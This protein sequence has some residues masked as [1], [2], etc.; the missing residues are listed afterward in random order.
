MRW[1]ILAILGSAHLARAG[2]VTGRLLLYG[3]PIADYGVAIDGRVPVPV[4]DAEGRFALD[5]AAGRHRIVFA[6]DG[7]VR[8]VVERVDVTSA[9]ID[10]GDVRAARGHRITGTVYDA[11]QLPVAG[12]TVLVFEGKRPS[13]ALPDLEL[14]ALG[15]H[16]AISGEDGT[17]TLDGV[18]DVQL[19][20][21]IVAVHGNRA[22]TVR[23]LPP[24]RDEIDHVLAP[25]GAIVGS[26]ENMDP[27]PLMAIATSVDH[28]DV[29]YEDMVDRY[30]GFLFDQLPPG[31]YDVSLWLTNAVPV[32]V[33]V[34]A[35]ARAPV[36]FVAPRRTVDLVVAASGCSYVTL[37]GTR[38]GERAA[39]A[40][41]GDAVCAGPTMTFDKLA[42][43]TYRVCTDDE[44]DCRTLTVTAMP[45]VQRV[46]FTAPAPTS[47]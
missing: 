43:G 1:Y 10:L 5:V 21:R 32:R 26:I 46:T 29:H 35:N 17:Y 16:V 25:T 2:T 30:S 37:Y 39:T 15:A 4:H 28:P 3:E 42:P 11:F 34:R 23:P 27:L 18:L 22:S 36:R 8:H 9:A 31:T 19:A 14:E 13:L 12:A 20:M 45:R 41:I 38:A 7:F 24:G 44:A 47:P 40:E 33:V 6:G